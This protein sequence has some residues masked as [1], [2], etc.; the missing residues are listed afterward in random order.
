MEGQDR[1]AGAGYV[2]DVG[3]AY[4]EAVSAAGSEIEHVIT[5]AGER[6]S[7]HFAGRGLVDQ[8]MPAFAHLETGRPGGTAPSVRI[9]DSAST[10]VVPPPVPW[11]SERVRASVELR[12]R[13]DAGIWGVFDAES[14]AMTVVDERSKR[15]YVHAPGPALPWN[16]RAAPLRSALHWLLMAP[17]R[18]LMH[19][20]TV[21]AKR[22]GALIVGRGGSGKTTLALACMDAGLDYLG[23]DYVLLSMDEPPLAHSLFAT[24]KLTPD[25]FA[26]LPGF[27]DCVAYPGSSDDDKAVLDVGRRPGRIREAAPVSAVLVP[28]LTAHGPARVRGASGGVA[29]LAL[30]PSTIFQHP[31]RDAEAMKMMA[32]LVR[33]VPCYTVE[34]GPD[35]AV[36]ARA[37]VRLLDR[38]P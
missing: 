35:P 23:D 9:W 33:M 32:Q 26:M 3:A 8:V 5:I 21:G 13:I 30:G 18:H 4:R 28:R 16:Q 27:H 11:R 38:A 19:A 17:R 24:A 2:D 34:V 36:A 22:G 1:I 14:D 6:L 7:L 25:S 37:I 31:G 29:L 20:A 12:V 15:A 10:G